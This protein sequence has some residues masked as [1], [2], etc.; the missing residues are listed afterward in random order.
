MTLIQEDDYQQV[1]DVTQYLNEIGQIPLLSKEEEVELGKRILN[2]DEEARNKLIASNLRLVISIAKHYKN[3]EYNLSFLDL[4]QAG[5]IG[6]I[7]AVDKFD[8]TLGYRF[9]TFAAEEI[10][11][12]IRD[13]ITK[14]RI[15]RISTEKTNV[16]RLLSTVIE[17]LQDKLDREPTIQ[18]IA[19]EM[20]TPIERIEELMTTPNVTSS[21]NKLIIGLDGSQ[22]ELS[23]FIPSDCLTPEEE[24]QKQLLKEMIENL[25]NYDML[26]DKQREI[27]KLFYGFYHNYEYTLKEIANIYGIT[28]SRVGQLLASALKKIRYN[29]YSR[30]LIDFTDNPELSLENLNFY[31]TEYANNPNTNITFNANPS[32]I[33]HYFPR[34]SKEQINTVIEELDESDK[35]Q[36]KVIFGDNLDFP[37]YKKLNAEQRNILFNI[38][39]PE[40]KTR[41]EEKYGKNAKFRCKK[42]EK[43]PNPNQGI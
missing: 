6:L 33:Y 5:N 12:T 3:R 18:E 14:N 22:D 23:Y 1:D 2:G 17:K 26:N 19:I 35:E 16:L 11:K 34:Y 32:K 29:P 37:T 8:A 10:K 13:E 42:K 40:I 41:L 7:N 20:Q 43:N 28:E 25:L 38:L 21:L 30:K 27:V 15:I 9:S 36:I 39:I 4:V 31:R 24:W